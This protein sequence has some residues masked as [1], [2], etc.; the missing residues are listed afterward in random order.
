MSIYVNIEKNYGTFHLSVR[1]DAGDETL[2]LLGASGSGKSLTLKCIAGVERPDRG[3]IV[4]DGV[5]LFDSERRIDLSPQERRTGLVFQ[6]YALFP[7]MTVL[8]NIRAGARREPD[9]Q[10]RADNVNRIVERFGLGSL[11]G[12][13]PAMLSGGQQQRVA[14]ARILVSEPRILLLDEPFSALDGHLRHR[15]EDELKQV[16]ESFGKTVVLV[17][18][19]RK[20]VFRLSDRIAVLEE[21]RVGAV[22]TKEEIFRNPGTRSGAALTGC[23]NI[24]R[25]RP[26]SDRLVEATDWGIDLFVDAELADDAEQ[27]EYAGIRSHDIAWAGHA[28]SGNPPE[29]VYRFDVLDEIENPFSYTV[30]LRAQGQSDAEPMQWDMD[31]PAWERIRTPSVDVC[32]PPMSILLLKK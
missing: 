29:N 4:V 10:K 28:N 17:S 1:L 32:L 2:A 3:R 9:A 11:T 24:S 13:T 18:H 23:K 25:I 5:T 22:G 21:G 16:I 31:K 8:E 12:H 15:M 20:E 14:L 30:I 6:N 26:K 19:N 27:K 7:H